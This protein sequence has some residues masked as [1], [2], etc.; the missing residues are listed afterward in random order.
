MKG[1]VLK[2]NNGA[3]LVNTTNQDLLVNNGNIELLFPKI[4]SQA[5]F[6]SPAGSGGNF[7]AQLLLDQVLTK[8]GT[9]VTTTNS[10][11]TRLQLITAASSGA[12]A[13][14]YQNTLI[15]RGDHK[16]L[17]FFRFRVSNITNVRF[18]IGL[19]DSTTASSMT[20]SD[21]PAIGYE[22]IQFSTARGDTTLKFVRRS[23]SGGS[24]TLTDTSVT[25]VS[26]ATGVYTLVLD[27]DGTNIRA[28]LIN[29]QETIVWDSGT[30]STNLIPAT[31]TTGCRWIIETLEN[32]G[33]T[34]SVF[35]RSGFVMR[36]F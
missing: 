7:N 34:L 32:V 17:N 20:T 26:G 3:I 11:G 22:G 31:T 15:Q 21:D 18:F 35:G 5:G 14:L 30:L 28:Y 23:S 25:A 9:N 24:Q 4:Y 8:T 2:D 10:E 12:V 29:Y 16:C 33:K 36:I 27:K 6:V 1:K 19:T 13:S